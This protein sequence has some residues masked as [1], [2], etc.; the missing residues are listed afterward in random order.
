ME[1]SSL[2]GPTRLDP[3]HDKIHFKR[4]SIR[5]EQWNA[6]WIKR[7]ILRFGKRYS[8]LL[9]RPGRGMASPLDRL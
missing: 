6:V 3:M 1:P 9:L 8:W 4:D 2:P 5:T 7:F